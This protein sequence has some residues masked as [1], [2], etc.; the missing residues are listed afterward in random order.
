MSGGCG[1]QGRAGLD[2]RVA[3]SAAP[4]EW[5]RLQDISGYAVGDP[6]SG[7]MD[8]IARQMSVARRGLDVAVAEQ[9]SDHRQSLPERQRTRSEAVAQ[10]V[11]S[12]IRRSGTRERQ[13]PGEALDF[14]NDPKGSLPWSRV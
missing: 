8:R 10:V 1:L 12:A 7:V 3:R 2:P 4:R 5:K 13:V 9:L 6:L 14:G 11:S